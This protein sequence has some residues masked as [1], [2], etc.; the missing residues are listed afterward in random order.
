[1]ISGRADDPVTKGEFY[2]GMSPVFVF[3]FAVHSTA[4]AGEI[5]R[6]IILLLLL[7][8]VILWGVAWRRARRLSKAS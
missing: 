7:A 3:L 8:G 4:D 5:I 2:L 1:M 6:V